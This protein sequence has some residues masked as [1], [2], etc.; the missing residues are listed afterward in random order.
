VLLLERGRYGSDTLSTHALMRGAVMQLARWGLL[1][2]VQ[3]AGTPAIVRT[4]FHY[5]D[6]VATVPIKARDGVPALFAP[7]RHILDRI[8]IDAAITAGADVRYGITVR[9]LVHDSG[10]VRGVIAADHDGQVLEF[11]A[12]LVVM[13]RS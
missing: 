11:R 5:D 7:R 4:C 9:D 13:H 6:A 12:A 3:H 1:S 8:V 2:T 10:R